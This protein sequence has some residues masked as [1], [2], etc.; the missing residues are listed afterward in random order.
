ML[1]DYHMRTGKIITIDLDQHE[2]KD[3]G[4]GMLMYYNG[5]EPHA[6]I[7]NAA[8][9]S[10]VAMHPDYRKRH[11]DPFLDSPPH[12]RLDPRDMQRPL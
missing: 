6:I 9:I 3:L 4:N 1:I 2:V 7:I 8:D 5:E 12:R 10:W 11:Y